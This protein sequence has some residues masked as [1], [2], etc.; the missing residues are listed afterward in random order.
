MDT[1]LATNMIMNASANATAHDSENLITYTT[2]MKKPRMLTTNKDVLN[3]A[4][5]AGMKVQNE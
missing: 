3:G 1:R 5:V 2:E 4:Y